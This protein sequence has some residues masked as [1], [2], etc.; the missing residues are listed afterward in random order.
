MRSILRKMLHRNSPRGQAM[1][2]TTMLTGLMLLWGVSMTHFW[3]DSMNAL[4]IYMDSFYFMLS[5]P[6][7]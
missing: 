1:T 7:P 2:E 5:L 4:Q 3:P 6:V